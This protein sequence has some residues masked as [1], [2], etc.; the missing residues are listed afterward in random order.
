VTQSTL[1]VPEMSCE[2]CRASIEG[3]VERLPGVTAVAVDL[4]RKLVTIEH[5]DGLAPVDRLAAAVEEQGYG[6]AS[7]G[8]P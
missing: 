5:D 8:A 3:A 6:V 7:L 2:A 4:E 1:S